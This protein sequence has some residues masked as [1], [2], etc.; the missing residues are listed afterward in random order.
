M[1]IVRLL[2]L[3]GLFVF[4]S[5]GLAN[6]PLVLGGS[7]ETRHVVV[8]ADG[9]THVGVWVEAPVIEEIVLRAPISLSLVIDVSGSMNGS[10]IQ[11][12]KMAASSLVESLADGD[13]VSLVTFND[14]VHV[15]HPTVELTSSSRAVLH[16]LIQG[17]SAMGGTNLHGGLGAG[18]QYAAA[19]PSSHPVRRVVLI[20]DGQGNVGPSDPFS[21]GNLSA[22]GSERRVQVSAIGVGMDYDEHSLSAIAVRSAGRFYH[23]AN[24]GALPGILESEIGLLAQTVATD[25]ILEIVPAP[26]VIIIEGLTPGARLEGNKLHMPLGALHSGQRRELLFRA[27]VQ[28]GAPGSK[29]LASARL[30]YGKPGGGASNMNRD[31]AVEVTRDRQIAARSAKDARV[32]ALVAEHRASA[33]ELRAAEALAAGNQAHA[34]AELARAEQEVAR[35]AASAPATSATRKRLESK[36][37]TLRNRSQSAAGASTPAAR[38]AVS[39]EARDSAMESYGY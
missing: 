22:Q 9:E 19:A 29:K 12:A 16:R 10:K 25:V 39:L 31:I 32:T 2:A 5:T 23:L 37:S 20:S 7:S 11:Y 30:R 21:L 1:T 35:A 36:A 3:F 26:G 33:A 17:I 6:S 38:R 4:P 27:R 24:P 14:Q 15:L 8:G 34:A 18:I 28:D 13:R